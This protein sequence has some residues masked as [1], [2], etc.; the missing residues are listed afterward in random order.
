M[1][2]ELVSDAFCPCGECI[3]IAGTAPSRDKAITS[4]LEE[5]DG[6]SSQL[7]GGDARFNVKYRR[8]VKVA[9]AVRATAEASA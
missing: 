1:S 5:H 7:Q 8:F 9:D 4:F 2:D 6:C 3:V